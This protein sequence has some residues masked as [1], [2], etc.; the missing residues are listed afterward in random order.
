M[1]FRLGERV[2]EQEKKG[3]QE[4]G[5]EG[6]VGFVFFSRGLALVP[7]HGGSVNEL[8]FWVFFIVL[9]LSDPEELQKKVKECFFLFFSCVLPGVV[10]LRSRVEETLQGCWRSRG[11]A[12]WGEYKSRRFPWDFTPRVSQLGDWSWLSA[13]EV[14]HLE[15]RVLESCQSGMWE[16]PWLE[17]HNM[18]N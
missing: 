13:I 9:L 8:V 5:K 16:H 6:L 18:R 2:D 12:N 3:K 7:V 17:I 1:G 15:F 4:G 11:A 10:N 14:L